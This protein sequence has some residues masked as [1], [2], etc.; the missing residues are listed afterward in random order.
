MN[1][2]VEQIQVFYEIAV[3]IGK[4]LNLQK[5]LR[6]A[7]V[8][9]LK[10]LNCIS[11]FVY[12]INY[13]EEKV[14]QINNIFKI[15]YTLKIENSYP[16]INKMILDSA[17][18]NKLS[19]FYEDLPISGETTS[20]QFFHIMKLGDFGFLVLIKG[21]KYLDREVLSA[22]KEIN[23]K[24]AQ[25]CY[26]CINNEDLKENKRKLQGNLLQQELVSEIALEL[27]SLDQFEIRINKI[28]NK[29]GIYSNVGR[30]YIFEDKGAYTYNIYEWRNK[31]ISH[32]SEY[33]TD[34]Y[35]CREYLNPWCKKNISS[36]KEELQE[37]S[38]EIVLL[39]KEILTKDGLL[40]SE[41]ISELPENIRILLEPE[42]IKSIVLYPLFVQNNYYG[43][44]GFDEYIE[45]KNRSKSEL[46]LL[47]TVSGIIANAFER[48]L[49]EQSIIDERDKAKKANQAKS[50]FLANMSHEIRTP[51]NAILGFSEALYHKLETEQH[52][53]MI[54]SVLSSGNLLLSLLND[55]LDLSKIEAGKLEISTQ[56]VDMKHI[57]N[58][59]KLLFSEKANKKGIG[60][61]TIINT[62]FPEVIKLDE[63]R[64]KQVIFNIVGNAIKFTH[65]GYI[66]L[67]ADFIRK[68]DNRGDLTIKVEDTGIG[69]PESQ[70]KKI[71]EAFRQQSG[72][73]IRKY[74]GV[75]LGLAIS[76]RL[77]K[78]MNGKI[79]VS[80][81]MGKGSTFKIQIPN[82]EIS[83]SRI[84]R[85]DNF[86]ENLNIIFEKANVLIVD[87]VL[88]NVETVE[89][90]LSFTN[91]TSSSAE[92]GEIALE[93]LKYYS[94][95][96][97]LLDMRMPGIDGY[98]TAKRIKSNPEKAHIP[99]IAFTASVFSSD[100]IE[101]SDDF[102]GFLYKPVNRNEL[103]S[104]LAEFLR[105][106]TE[107]IQI[108]T[109][110]S[111]D[112]EIEKLS[113]E[114]IKA[115]PEIRR[116]LENDFLH[117]WENIKGQFVLYKIEEFAID[118]SQL[119]HKY[120][121]RLLINYAEKI[122]NEIE[123]IDL[124]AIT[125]TL[126]EFPDIIEKISSLM[127]KA[128]NE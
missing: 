42:G 117:Q 89:N 107:D 44:I 81:I 85:K 31:N 95:D 56:P 91:L 29:I 128:S 35:Q 86:D 52:R 25:A 27:N 72:Q 61:D 74:G 6:S 37:K 55:I 75:G 100:K 113:K 76:K 18:E 104:K 108:E 88:T 125:E 40:Y 94:P 45:R 123:D 51:M 115:L 48:K 87:D 47:R 79:S 92:N 14:F 10:K 26:A 90:F 36:N 116:I 103:L 62:D 65:Q 5:M 34:I 19:E 32:K 33:N 57:L 106:R 120:K 99:I 78:K 109:E 73:S 82:I 98:E 7:V 49:M 122:I 30:A 12:R 9:Y 118:L 38:N 70:Y 93:I 71:F 3:S 114:N 127:N 21:R 20:K 110:P 16:E 77:I 64:I 105:H 1:N 97:I 22:L 23:S 69:V 101:K 111:H 28:L 119:A 121:L 102:D 46:E 11:G 58:E 2:S 50:E 96:L 24:L 67:R 59:I 43:F 112:I 15:P 17:E 41:N 39:L 4:S 126:S 13:S 84:K 54:K 83:E 8:T 63:I 60:I 68:S 80:S 53:K 124:E 66:N